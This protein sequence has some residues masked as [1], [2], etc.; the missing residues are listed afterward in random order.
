MPR[1]SPWLIP[2]MMA[3][4]R[5]SW[6]HLQ[7]N[8]HLH[9]VSAVISRELLLLLCLWYG[10]IDNIFWNLIIHFM[11]ICYRVTC[12]NCLIWTELIHKNIT[13][14]IHH[15]PSILKTTTT[16]LCSCCY[17]TFYTILSLTSDAVFSPVKIR[18]QQKYEAHETTRTTWDY[19]VWP[20]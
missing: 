20:H 14:P 4:L 15:S 12:L 7:L 16:Q 19:C 11:F 3:H 10:D 6:E 13:V 8:W 5:K 17:L 2:P 1:I 18:C 9:I